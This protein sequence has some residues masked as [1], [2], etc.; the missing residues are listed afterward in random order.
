MPFF[1]ASASFQ[2]LQISASLFRS[3]NFTA[4]IRF[5]DSTFTSILRSRLGFMWSRLLPLSPN[6]CSTTSVFLLVP[7]LASGPLCS[8]SRTGSREWNHS[9]SDYDMRRAFKADPDHS[10]SRN[11]A[12][13]RDFSTCERYGQENA[14][15]QEREYCRSISDSWRRGG[16]DI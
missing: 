15:R 7:V 1:R 14:I 11:A 3:N 4:I 12:A 10:S 2:H 6:E 9:K 8:P 13:R 16:E 5:C